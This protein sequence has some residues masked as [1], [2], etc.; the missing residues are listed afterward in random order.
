MF[1]LK[2]WDLVSIS[3]VP[4]IMTLGNSMFIP[5]LPTIQ[6]KL[7]ISTF[8]VS[9][10]IGSVGIGLMLP[11]LDAFITQG[12]E[13]TERGTVSAIYS[14]MRFIGVSAGPPLVSVLEQISFRALFITMAGACLV[15][16]VCTLLMIKP[17]ANSPLDLMSDERKHTMMLR[18]KVRS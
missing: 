8:Q 13:K 7:Q 5:I 3:S 16:A 1:H 14:S 12:I 4:L 17:K 11:C 2:K 10:I 15:A 18:R 9:M 6:K